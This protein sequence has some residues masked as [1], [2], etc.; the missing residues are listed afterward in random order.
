MYCVTTEWNTTKPEWVQRNLRMRKAEIIKVTVD[1][2]RFEEILERFANRI[3]RHEIRPA[4][5]QLG[6]QLLGR[7]IERQLQEVPSLADADGAAR[8]SA[9]RR[10]D[11]VGRAGDDELPPA[12]AKGEPGGP[13][14]SRAVS[15]IR[16][17]CTPDGH[18]VSQARQSKQR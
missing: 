9:D 16:P 18:A 4:R 8:A 14:C 7:R 6:E 15:A 1:G 5:R 13:S 12:R 11:R 3:Q 17:Y 10:D 2:K